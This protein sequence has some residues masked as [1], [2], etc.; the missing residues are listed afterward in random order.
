MAKIPSHE[1]TESPSEAGLDS[2]YAVPQY[3]RA[4]LHFPHR[5]Q[6]PS[7]SEVTPAS[8]SNDAHSRH[9]LLASTRVVRHDRLNNNPVLKSDSLLEFDTPP[10]GLSPYRRPKR[11]GPIKLTTS[12][13]SS[14]SPT[15]LPSSTA[16]RVVAQARERKGSIVNETDVWKNI[17]LQRHEEDADKFR[18][19]KLQERYWEIW[20]L[21][22]EWIRVRIIVI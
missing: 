12:T 6:S 15:L 5:V 17:E 11:A 19:D 22:F 18:E 16:H 1:R 10:L 4:S 7:T 14:K 20:K 8:S 9:L 3:Q 2:E 13:T 21:G